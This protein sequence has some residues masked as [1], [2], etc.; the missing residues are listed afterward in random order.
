MAYESIPHLLWRFV[1]RVSPSTIIQL[2]PSEIPMQG[3]NRPYIYKPRNSGKV[4]GC[5][6][7]GMPQLLPRV[8]P[9]P[10]LH[11]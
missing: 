9:I 11:Y 5:T 7:P 3:Q 4:A 6:R 1:F 10:R 2:P 8:I